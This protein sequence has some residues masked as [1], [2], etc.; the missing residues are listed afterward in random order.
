[1]ANGYYYTSGFLPTC[2]GNNYNI[3]GVWSSTECNNDYSDG[4]GAYNA[5]MSE[6]NVAC[7]NKSSK[8]DWI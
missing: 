2:I 8:N 5:G 4:D 3:I 7:F 1:M 6:G